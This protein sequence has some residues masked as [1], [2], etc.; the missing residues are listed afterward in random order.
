MWIFAVIAV[1]L[2]ALVPP[3]FLSRLDDERAVAASQAR[4]IAEGMAV[5]R[6]SVVDWAHDHPL[7][8]G[9]VDAAAVPTPAWWK[10]H[11]EVRAAVQGRVV[12][13]YLSTEFPGVLDEMLRLSSGSIWVGTASQAS[14][15][16]HSPSMGDTGIRLPS[17]VP[18]QAPVWAA[19]RD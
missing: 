10:R 5:Y 3:L 13:V 1:A 17:S 8:E 9:L 11:P 19:L 15:T 12:A 16:L 18:D 4:T 6:H 14:G 7:A 2:A